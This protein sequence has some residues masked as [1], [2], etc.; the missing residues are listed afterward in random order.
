VIPSFGIKKGKWA[1]GLISQVQ[2]SASLL[3]INPD[4][5]RYVT[6][7]QLGLEFV[8]FAIENPNNQRVN[9]TSWI[10]TGFVIGREIWNNRKSK[11]SLGSNIKLIFPSGYTNVAM[12]NF[13]GTLVV[14]ENVVTLTDA[15]ATINFSY[16]KAIVD[17]RSFTVDYSNFSVGKVNGVGLDLGANYQLKNNNKVWLNTGVSVKNMGSM[18][19]G[20]GQSN[21]T[22]R[23]NIPEGQSFRIDLLNPNFREIESTFLESGFFSSESNADGIEVSLPTVFSANADLSLTEVFYMSIYG[24]TFIQSKK[25]NLQ[26]P[27]INLLAVTPSAVFGNFEIYSPW[28]YNDITGFTG[29]LGFRYGGFFVGSQSILTALTSESKKADVQIGLSWGFGKKIAESY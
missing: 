17:P 19:F 15:V 25:D 16:N 11:L 2:A 4:I 29:G 1:F 3:D 18:K 7:N 21:R 28:G 26:I 23:M 5:G 22:F 24:Q 13:S 27:A 12:G 20:S 14:E 9:G 10:E 8:R 6:D